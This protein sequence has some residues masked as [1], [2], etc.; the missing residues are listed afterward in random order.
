MLSVRG[1]CM[2]DNSWWQRHLGRPSAPAPSNGSPQIPTYP[3][4]AV[5]WEES[6]PPTGPRQEMPDIQPG[7]NGDDTYLRVRQ[8]GYNNRAPENVGKVGRC[9]RCGGSNFFRRRWANTEAAPLCTDC[10]HNGDLFEQSGTALMG[11]G[12]KSS[13]PIQTARTDNPEA[14]ANF[15]IDASVSSDFSWSSV[16]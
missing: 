1:A 11:A 16:R 10:G 5:R 14:T 4:K 7:G 6:Y 2:S 3:Q 8:Q 12:V 13:G 9:P 15:G